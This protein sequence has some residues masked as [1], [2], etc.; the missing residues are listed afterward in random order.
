M[1]KR[2]GYLASLLGS[3]RTMVICKD[4]DQ[5]PENFA[6][7]WIE[8]GKIYTVIIFRKISGDFFYE[9]EGVKTNNTGFHSNRF[10]R[11]YNIQSLN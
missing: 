3:G 8:K 7:D 1:Q 5:K 2:S 6:G 9:L 11:I 10:Q 4:D